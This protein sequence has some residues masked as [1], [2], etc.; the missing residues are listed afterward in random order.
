MKVILCNTFVHFDYNCYVSLGM[1]NFPLWHHILNFGAFLISNFWPE[2]AQPVLNKYC[3]LPLSKS[4]YLMQITMLVLLK[5]TVWEMLCYMPMH[6]LN[7][8]DL[9]I[10]NIPDA[11]LSS[12][13]I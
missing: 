6:I 11:H 3:K 8:H 4:E 12:L 2:D 9:R 1:E 10:R 13:N 7:I 5:V